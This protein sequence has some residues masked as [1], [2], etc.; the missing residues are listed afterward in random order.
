[1]VE[2]LLNINGNFFVFLFILIYTFSFQWFV[3]K[4]FGSKEK[5][6]LDDCQNIKFQADLL[7]YHK[8][9]NGALLK[10]RER[11]QYLC[12]INNNSMLREVHSS[13]INC[14]LKLNILE[15]AE[16]HVEEL[17]STLNRYFEFLYHPNYFC[18][19]ILLY[20]SL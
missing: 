11:L 10:Y 13:I 19:Y 15:E 20:K 18:M 9:Y 17:V 2:N 7:F 8:N 4:D 12:H 14:L 16:Y 6:T 1:V 5:M 3:E